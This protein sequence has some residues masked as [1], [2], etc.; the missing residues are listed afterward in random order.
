MV[1]KLVEFIKCEI[2]LMKIQKMNFYSI[3]TLGI[4]VGL[5]KSDFF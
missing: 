4:L 5:Q 2:F 3:K 1:L